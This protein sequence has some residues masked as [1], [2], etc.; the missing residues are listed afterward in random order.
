MSRPSTSSQVIHWSR[1][2]LCLLAMS[3]AAYAQAAKDPAPAAPGSAMMQLP[4]SFEENRGQTDAAVR[5]LSRGAGYTLFLTDQ[6]AV[7]TVATRERSRSDVLRLRLEGANRGGLQGADALPGVSHYLIGNDPS[8]WRTGITNYQR[9][10]QAQVYPGIDLEYYGNAQRM[11]HDFILAPGADPAAIVWKIEGARK[12]EIGADGGLRLLTADGEARFD[13]PD[14]YQEIEGRRVPVRGAFRLLENDRVG[15]TVGDYDRSHTLVIDPVLMYSTYLGGSSGTT[16]PHGIALDGSLNAYVVGETTETSFPSPGGTA[17]FGTQSGTDVFV[18]KINATGSALTYVTFLGG[19]GTDVGNGIAVSSTGEVYITGQSDSADYPTNGSTAAAQAAKGLGVDAIVSRL[20]TNGATLLYSTYLGGDGTDAATAIAIEP[21]GAQIYVTGST[22]SA[23]FPGLGVNSYDSTTS[24]TDAFLTRIVGSTGA[25]GYSTVIGGDKTEIAHA[26][27]FVSTSVVAIAGE[28]QDGTVGNKFPTTASVVQ[29]ANAGN[30]G[31]AGNVDSTDGFVSVF[32]PST[33]GVGS[34][35]A[36]TMLGGAGVDVIRGMTRDSSGLFLLTGDADCAAAAGAANTITGGKDLFIARLTQ[37]LQTLGFLRYFGGAGDEIGMGIARDTAN[38][39]YV[40]GSTTSSG[41]GTTDALFATRIGG[42]D[43]FVARF[44]ANGGTIEIFTYLGTTGTDVANAIATDSVNV[45][46]TSVN[47]IAGTTDTNTF[48]VTGSAYEAFKPATSTQ[49]FVMRLLQV[50]T[51]SGLSL[52]NTAATQ[53]PANPVSVGASVTYTYTIRIGAGDVTQIVFDA[54]AP[55]LGL[56]IT[57]IERTANIATITLSKT[58]PFSV[59]NLVTVSG[60]ANATF[61]G[62][63]PIVNV[64]AN[65]LDYDQSVPGGFANVASTAVAAG[66]AQSDSSSPLLNITSVTPPVGGSCTPTLPT[67]R[68]ITCLLGNVTANNVDRAVQIVAQPT[69]AAACSGACTVARIVNRVTAAS[70]EKQTFTTTTLTTNVAPSVTLNLTGTATANVSPSPT[71]VFGTDSTL[72]YLITTST[73]AAA[74]SSTASDDIVVTFVYPANFT[75]SSTVPALIAGPLVL[76]TPNCVNNAATHTVQCSIQSIAANSSANVTINGSFGPGTDNPTLG[77]TASVA[78]VPTPGSVIVV[79]NS[80]ITVNVDYHGPAADLSMTSLVGAPDPARPTDTITYTGSYRNNGPA[81]TDVTITQ[82]FDY[83]FLATGGT[84]PAGCSQ[85]GPGQNVVC[86]FPAKAP[87]AGGDPDYTYS[88]SGPVPLSG[89]VAQITAGSSATISSTTSNESAAGDETETSSIHIQRT[90]DLSLSN[91]LPANATTI[92]ASQTINYSVDVTNLNAPSSDTATTFDVVFTLTSGY[93]NLSGAGCVATNATTVTC[94]VTNL[95]AGATANV[96]FTANAPANVPGATPTGQITVA[97]ALA[98]VTSS[99][100]GATGT[101]SIAAHTITVERKADL[102]L[103]AFSDNS[104]VRAVASSLVYTVQFSNNNTVGF[105]DAATNVKLKLTVPNTDV[106]FQSTTFNGG[107]VQTATEI[108]CD[109]TTAMSAGTTLSRTITVTPIHPLPGNQASVT[110]TADA[111]VYS[112]S[113]IDDGAAGAPGANNTQP[114]VTTTVQR[115]SNLALTFTGPANSGS[116]SNLTYNVGVTNLG[117]DQATSVAVTIDLPPS[118]VFVSTTLGGGCVASDTNADLQVDRLTCAVGTL[119]NAASSNF[120]VTITPPAGFVPANQSQQDMNG[121]GTVSGAVVDN[122]PGNN[123]PI[124][125]T[126]TIQKQAD[127]SINM[128]DG[129]DPVNL[130]QDLTYSVTVTASGADVDLVTVTDTLPSGANNFTANSISPSQGT[131]TATPVLPGATITCNL[132]LLANG[133]SAAIQI[134]GRAGISTAAPSG[135]ISN[136]VSVSSVSIVD[137]NTGNN[138]SS[139]STL[140]QR[141]SDL[142][143]TQFSAT[144]NPFTVTQD[145][146]VTYSAQVTNLGPDT[147]EGVVFTLPLPASTI[148][149]QSAS[150]G[151]VNSSNTVT[152][153]IGQLAVGVPANLTIVGTPLP[154]AGANGTIN[155]TATVASSAVTDPASGNNSA[156]N[157]VNVVRIADLTVAVAGPGTPTVVGAP[158]TQNITYTI[159]ATNLGD[160]DAPTATIVDTLPTGF[161]YVGSTGTCTPAGN[162]VTCQ[163]TNLNVGTPQQI[164]ITATP[165]LPLSSSSAFIINNVSISSSSVNDTGAHGGTN[166]A[167][168]NDEFRGTADLALSVTATPVPQNANAPAGEVLAGDDLLYQVTLTNNGPYPTDDIT[169]TPTLPA[170]VVLVNVNPLAFSCLGTTCSLG[171]LGAGSSAQFTVRVN[172]PPGTVTAQST[173]L[174]LGVVATA[175]G[176]GANIGAN[177]NDP[178]NTNNNITKNATARKAADLAVTQSRP[179]NF[180]LTNQTAQFDIVVANTSNLNDATGVVLT[181]ALTVQPLTSVSSGTVV[182]QIVGGGTC[183]VAGIG[184]AGATVTCNLGTIPV[185]TSK[186]VNLTMTPTQPGG[187][188]NLPSVTLTEIDPDT[189]NNAAGQQAVIV[190]NTPVGSPV[191]VNPADPTTGIPNPNVTMVFGNVTTPG[192]SLVAVSGVGP[193]IPTFYQ[194][195][196]LGTVYYDISSTAGPTSP[197]EVCINITGN[198]YLKPERVRIFE[199]TGAGF[200]DI[201]LADQY[202]VGTNPAKICGQALNVNSTAHSFIVAAPFNNPPV[203]GGTASTRPVSGKGVT[204]AAIRLDSNATTDPDINACTIIPS[205][206]APLSANQVCTDKRA[207]KYTWTGNF[208]DGT[209]KQTDCATVSDANFPN[210]CHQIDVSVPF[211][212]QTFVLTA[213]D[214]YGATNSVQ[215]NLTVTGSGGAPGL[216]DTVTINAG[217][218]ANFQ[219]DYTYT[220]TTTFNVAVSPANNTI[221]CTVTPNPVVY[222]AGGPTQTTTI[223]VGCSTQAPRFASAD[224]APGRSSSPGGPLVAAFLGLTG[225]PLL[226]VVLL[227]ARSPRRRILKVFAA[228]GLILVM[229]LFL[230]SCGGGGSFGGGPTQV[231]AGTARG[232][233][234]VTVTGNPAPSQQPQPFTI[235]VN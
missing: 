159:T 33:T 2:S 54:P 218:A 102:R 57:N 7:L 81:T 75:V 24:G 161:S 165:S 86:V 35:V 133:G 158:L 173:N 111:L 4:L 27:N 90:T 153:T 166:A 154:P 61:N 63:F 156:N 234:T 187:V 46:G 206:G 131:C 79:T 59:G 89:S 189:A 84:L 162:V 135:V 231:S 109:H 179:N 233:Y 192:T 103:L 115:Q 41:L 164:Q 178:N 10:R 185:G 30:S 134:T 39:M 160:S 217:Q 130:S 213:T 71:Y 193:V 221:V 73:G 76:N 220:A 195:G 48:P 199:F 72:A 122:T 224:P 177:V 80:P 23:N 209:V 148:T 98:P 117:P 137:S 147:A 129:P 17:T 171:S 136:T 28:T 229:T 53:S 202:S 168:S 144:P 119:N 138:S 60:V 99:V 140:A 226:G 62:T 176:N 214:A 52:T 68:G 66:F 200:T 228:I 94:T 186:T 55:Q 96:A 34:L 6:E 112:D 56:E 25:I 163:L 37:N 8:K 207:M 50:N 70:G 180:I 157:T 151:C 120:T 22:D 51:N 125:V 191:S 14:L 123:G 1:F 100:D 12:I 197:L 77:A 126:T 211:G 15:F 141:S 194:F 44:P 45:G 116:A 93:Q 82:S 78:I 139:T 146:T 18:A 167:T 87:L 232:T 225:L 142:A 204:G 88:F 150:P 216:G 32:N 169:V 11:E 101:K 91:L 222:T 184:T 208:T 95:A 108:T 205:L 16:V 145:T 104:P 74:A 3:L 67:G 26:I 43:A 105:G 49:G 65:T 172:V 235:I 152:C 210:G 92:Q 29:A 127:L 64:T 58:H 110:F 20:A 181:N 13:R 143:I 230:V 227:P 175:Y 118:F 155:T 215:V 40:V 188:V 19:S 114:T 223:N 31:C 106:T 190:G 128:T 203:A 212:A 83:P 69:A 107:C 124:T 47:F 42:Q 9:V 21:T 149:F 5:Y 85:A 170:G 38:R 36:S 132:G 183:A 174:A 182:G 113:V 201:T 198:V 196:S 121:I 97:V 219:F